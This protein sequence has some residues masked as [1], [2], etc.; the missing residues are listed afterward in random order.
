MIR[1]CS[2]LDVTRVTDAVGSYAQLRRREISQDIMSHR[3][4]KRLSQPPSH[5]V[6]DSLTGLL[7]VRK[8]ASW[9]T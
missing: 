4:S 1:P 8:M 2:K 6:H 3:Y 5:V 7:A 9:D